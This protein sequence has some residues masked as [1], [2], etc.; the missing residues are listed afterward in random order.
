M[1]LS[2]SE[3]VRNQSVQNRQST[4]LLHF[5]QLIRIQEIISNTVR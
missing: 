5:N 1:Q 2:V 3:I 4:S